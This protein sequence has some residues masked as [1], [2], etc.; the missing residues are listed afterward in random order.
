[1]TQQTKEI[2]LNNDESAASLATKML[3]EAMVFWHN[4]GQKII[5][6]LIDKLNNEG[7]GRRAAEIAK[8]W[9][10]VDDRWIDIAAK[11]AP[12]QSAKLSSVQINKKIEKRFVISAPQVIPEKKDWLEKVER[13]QAALPKPNVISNILQDDDT[14]DEVEYV[15]VNAY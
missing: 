3:E 11:L 15:D 13:D 4:E 5:K 1:M 9:R 2:I 10:G 6:L 7:E 8:I 14:I 12:Y